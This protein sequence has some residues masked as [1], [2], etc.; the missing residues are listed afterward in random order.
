MTDNFNSNPN[1]KRIAVNKEKCDDT[2][3]DNYYAKVNLIALK[4]AMHTLSLKAFELWIYFAK[5]MDKHT[6]YLSKVD[7]LNWSNVKGT[8]Y[9]NA[10]KELQDNNYLI[11][12]DKESAEPKNFNFYEIPKEESKTKININKSTVNEIVIEAPTR[13]E[14]KF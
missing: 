2:S 14:F 1:Q 6:F 7:F 9:Y 10:F 8:S 12:I 4:N 5:N 11:P 13:A 3:I